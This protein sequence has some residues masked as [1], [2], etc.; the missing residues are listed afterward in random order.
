MTKRKFIASLD[1][2]TKAYLEAAL[3]ATTDNST[4]SGGEPLDANY[5]IGDF[6]LKALQEA[7]ADCENF[8]QDN[9]YDLA[10]AGLNMEEIGHNFFLSRNGHGSGFF[11]LPLLGET[12]NRLQK[13]AKVWGT[14]EPYVGDS[15]LL[16]WGG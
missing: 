14:S 6:T 10:N 8:Y 7:K 4:P 1:R 16:Y 9:E 12:K 11:D 3:W 2:M 5:D 15:G 13:S